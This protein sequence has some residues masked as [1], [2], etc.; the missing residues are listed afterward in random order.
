MRPML[1]NGP[2]LGRRGGGGTGTVSI[3][4]VNAEDT[5]ESPASASLSYALNSDGSSNEGGTAGTWLIGSTSGSLY[6]ARATVSSGSLSSGT[7]GSWLALSSN[8]AWRVTRS[9]LGTSTCTFLVEIR[10]AATQTAQ[11]SATI[12]LA[13]SVTSGGGGGGGGE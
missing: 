9:S 12:T 7:T 4:N 8:R 6:E 5:A 11:D 13:A 2:L 3:S 1:F 10:D